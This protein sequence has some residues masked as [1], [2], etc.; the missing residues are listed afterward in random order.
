VGVAVLNAYPKDTDFL[1]AGLGLNVLSTAALQAPDH[2]VLSPDATVVLVSASPE[3]RGHHA[4]YS[5]T[6]V[7]GRREGDWRSSPPTV[8]D[9]PIAY[10]SPGVT[11]QDARCLDTFP[12]WQAVL[13]HLALRHTNPRVAV[14]PC[15][16]MQIGGYQ[17]LQ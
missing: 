3:G 2:Q 5:P 17:D 12:T 15:G 8:G 6:M 7:Y 10:L 13:E 16:A 11:P 4:L 9:H 14:F 1:Q